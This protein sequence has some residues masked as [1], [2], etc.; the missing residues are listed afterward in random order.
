[1]FLT[2]NRLIDFD[3]AILSRI[4][5]TLKYIPLNMETRKGIWKSFLERAITDEGAAIYSPEQL[6]KLAQNKFNGREV[7][8]L[9]LESFLGES[10]LIAYL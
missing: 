4:H 3:E 5:L 8:F 2:T 6:N 10:M 9:S 7:G 1:M